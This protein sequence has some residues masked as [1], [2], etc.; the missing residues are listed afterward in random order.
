MAT[1]PFRPEAQILGAFRR[2]LSTS[3]AD[4]TELVCLERRNGW[5]ASD[6]GGELHP[7][8]TSVLVRVVEGRRLGWYRTDDPDPS[9]LEGGLRHALA[10]ATVQTPVKRRPV[11]LAAGD[12]SAL[13]LPESIALYDPEIDG[14]D[15]DTAHELVAGWVQ[16]G[17]RARLRW[18]ATRLTIRNSHGLE[19]SAM[20]TEATFEIRCGEHPGAG[21][22]AGSARTLRA[23]APSTIRARATAADAAGDP[24]LRSSI[25]RDDPP[26]DGPVLLSPEA[27][28]TLL[29]VI[30]T[31]ALSGRAFLEGSSFLT[32]H[33]NV[34]VF[35]RAFNL[36]DDAT[37][38]SGLAYPFD[39]EGA[40]KHPVDL[41]VR[42]TPTTPA[43][44]RHQGLL[45]GLPPTGQAVG[46]EDSFF[47]NLFL[48]PGDA[49]QSALLR[50][51]EGGHAI[52]WLE[53][54]ACLDP[55]NLRVRC[56][57]RGVRRVVNGGFGEA[58]PDR[59]WEDSLLRALGRIAAVGTDLVARAMPTTP[60][61]AISAPALVLQAA[62]GFGPT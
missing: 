14:L 35:D 28:I 57:A 12:A 36:R 24:E 58:V 42:G 20:A 18:S 55:T 56:R 3:P 1:S 5:A 6:G 53:R 30:N 17:E 32:R 49:D 8:L 45:S 26:G 13:V 62:E 31:H 46:G 27:V 11:F 16:D 50:A 38:A 60:L 7:T 61:G 37:A 23:L 21:R 43:L 9:L 22:A 33:R 40:A 44:S 29:D 2:V 48:L 41:I 52:G 59:I 34:Q 39:L 15:L 47:G 10:L 19:R 4:E 54:P 51:A 25:D